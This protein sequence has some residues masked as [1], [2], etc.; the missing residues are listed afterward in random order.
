MNFRVAEA[1]PGDGALCIINDQLVRNTV[2]EFKGSSVAGQPGRHFLVG[3]D[4]GVHMP[5]KTQG[6]DKDPGF[7]LIA[8]EN[9]DDGGT[10]PKIH[11]TCLCRCKIQHAG[12]VR[13]FFVKFLY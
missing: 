3:D 7:D 9:V 4:L 5:T 2:E 12:C 10:L 11:L 6:H 13:L 8:A 1:G